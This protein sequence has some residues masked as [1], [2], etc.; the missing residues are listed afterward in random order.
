M[1]AVRGFTLIE[2]MVVVAI[3]GL[4]ASLAIPAYIDH[5]RRAQASEAFPASADMRSGVVMYYSQHGQLP[6]GG[7]ADNAYVEELDNVGRYVDTV[8]WG[9]DQQIVVT[10]VDEPFEGTQIVLEPV[11]DG[12]GIVGWR[13]ETNGTFASRHLPNSCD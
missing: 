9:G 12:G 4:L 6:D 3:I 11:V 5:V 7:D 2:L 1:R 13:C 10:Y 8:E